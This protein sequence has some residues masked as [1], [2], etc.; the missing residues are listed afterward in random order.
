M[1]T[2]LLSI[3]VWAAAAMG[4]QADWIVIDG[5]RYS[6][7]LVYESSEVYYVRLPR[8]GRSLSVKKTKVGSGQIE[9]SDDPFYREELK[10]FYQDVKANGASAQERFEST[11]S[12]FQDTGANRTPTGDGSA[13]FSGGGGGAAGANAMA[14][15]LET[16]KGMFSQLGFQLT[17]SGENMT[18]KSPDGVITLTLLGRSG[19][20]TGISINIKTTD[21]N[22]MDLYLSG[23]T[24]NMSQGFPWVSTWLNSMKD[25]SGGFKTGK[26][27]QDGVTASISGSKTDLTISVEFG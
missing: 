8:E 18:G 22:M 13:F 14:V 20:M 15:P 21:Q 7:V 2:F 24:Q 26:K 17:K 23:M 5:K 11:D 25:P 9:I 1:R 6:D 3:S 19:M 16:M 4:V 27:T 10:T 12:A